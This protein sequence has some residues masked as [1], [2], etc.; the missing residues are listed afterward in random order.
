MTYENLFIY[1]LFIYL[2]LK[3]KTKFYFDSNNLAI[4]SVILLELF[5]IWTRLNLFLRLNP[6]YYLFIFNYL[7][8]F[9]I[10]LIFL[11]SI[12]SFINFLNLSS[13]PSLLIP[14]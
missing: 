7:I 3:G 4:E 9:L 8:H 13:F 1:D 2:K 12:N 10:V 5:Y 11:I 14:S 6:I